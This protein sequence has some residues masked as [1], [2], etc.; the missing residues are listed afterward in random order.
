MR[1]EEDADWFREVYRAS[2]ERNYFLARLAYPWILGRHWRWALVA[3]SY[4][5][6]LDDQI[7]EDE[8]PDAAARLMEGQHELIE[9]VYAGR[10]PLPQPA[11]PFQDGV[12][13][14]V[15]DRDLGGRCRAPLEVVL[16]EMAFDLKRV[17]DLLPRAQLD[18]HLVR[19][20]AAT[21]EL[22][23]VFTGGGH[24][25]SEE[26][27]RVGSLAYLWADHVI[28]LEDDLSR[29]LINVPAEEADGLIPIDH[30]DGWSREERFGWQAKMA[31]ELQ[32]TFRLA[33]DQSRELGARLRLLAR[34]MLRRKRSELTTFIEAAGSPAPAPEE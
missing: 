27:V 5:K 2:G 14:F 9:T 26:F 10:E 23:T 28:D 22:M 16:R 18:A 21:A 12:R 30:D 25:A 34:L 13:F 17:G 4:L 7:D 8:A 33:L 15:W 32:G 19:L 20:G 24:R 31:D 6:R 3:F 1:R 29:G 11:A